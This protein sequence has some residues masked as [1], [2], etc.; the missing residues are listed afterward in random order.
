VQA[1]ALHPDAIVVTSALLQVNC[2]VLRGAFEPGGAGPDSPLEIVEVPAGGGDPGAG[3]SGPPAPPQEPGAETFVID[4][5]ILPEELELLPSVLRQAGFPPPSGLLATHADWDHVLGPLAFSGVPLGCAETSAAR[6]AAAPGEPQRELRSFDEE[7]YLERPRPLA[8]DSLQALPAPGHCELGSRRLELHPAV[9]HTADGMAILAP[10]AS[11][12]IAGD[13]LS[14]VELPML[15]PGGEADA[16]LR[17]LERLRALVARVEHVVPGHGPVLDRKG[18]E[19]V[20]EEDATYLRALL[21]RGSRAELP[22]GRRSRE[23]RALHARN[24]ARLSI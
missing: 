22:P 8:L 19:R 6:L 2:V 3:P 11:V 16:Y 12:L 17:T 10:W 24:V 14:P 7:L 23:M 4:S 20:L 1:R 18:A 13:Y 5:P 9:G 21:E 15:S